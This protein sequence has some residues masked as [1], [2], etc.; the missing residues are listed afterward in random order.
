MSQQ[1]YNFSAGPAM[2]PRRVLLQ[3]QR[4]LTDYRGT[5]MS[6]MELSHRGAEFEDIYARAVSD[7]RV[8][9][10]IPPDYEVLF[11][12]GGATLQFTMVPMNLMG[13]EGADYLVTGLWSRKA[14]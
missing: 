10:D 4:E 9:L 1:V 11:L 14:F 5:G 7:L 6:V 12:Q 8:L 3:A 2:L 13:R